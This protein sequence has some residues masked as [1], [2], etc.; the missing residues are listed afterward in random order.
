[1]G[2]GTAKGGQPKFEKF[3][4]NFSDSIH[5]VPFIPEQSRCRQF[6]ER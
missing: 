6:F 2:A 3:D 4:E 5:L 1:M